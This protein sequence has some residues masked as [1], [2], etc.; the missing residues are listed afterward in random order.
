MILLDTDRVSVLANPGGARGERLSARLRAVTG[1]PV[2]IPI[3]AVEE[4]MRGWMSSIAKER[5]VERQV[6]SYRRLAY[7]FEFFTQ[8]QIAAFDDAAA[9][10]FETLSA[11]RV[12][13]MDLKIA[14]IALSTGAL[15]LTANRRDFERVP[16]LTFDS[17][18]E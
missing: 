13:T 14:A 18:L 3:I 7:L 11:V 6:S 10:R 8:F 5:H 17:W 15:L 12:G 2:T 16:G 9:A 4:Q 1:T